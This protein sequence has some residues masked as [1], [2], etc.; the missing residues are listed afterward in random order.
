MFYRDMRGKPP[1]YDR[2]SRMY[3]VSDPDQCLELLAMP[4]ISSIPLDLEVEALGRHFGVEYADIAILASH[5]PISQ[6]GERHAAA[7]RRFSEH[8]AARRHAVRAWVEGPMADSFQPLMQPGRVEVMGEVI[9]PMFLEL[10]VALIGQPLP[11]GSRLEWV[12]LLFDGLVGLR[13]RE[14]MF[15]Q[16]RELRRYFADVFGT[17]EDDAAVLLPMVSIVFGREPLIGT[18]GES[19]R[20][21][22]RDNPG[23]RF[24]EIDYP[25]GPC[26]TG[27]PYVERKVTAPIDFHGVALKPG[28]R[29]KLMLQSFSGEAADRHTRFFG[30]GPHVCPGRPVAIEIWKRSVQVLQQSQCR[31]SVVRYEVNDNNYLF[32]APK[33]LELELTQ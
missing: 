32:T 10:M 31:P 33:I 29:L 1:A 3:I 20:R 16:L 13:K 30:G 12:S 25:A 17:T 9:V 14:K 8:L 7:R 5:M 19:L 28:A 22:V 2:A 24:S 18:F 26:E 23:K 27:L 15:D 6:S 11:P 4:E 21:L